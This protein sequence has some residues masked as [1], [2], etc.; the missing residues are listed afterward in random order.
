[1]PIS[2]YRDISGK[3]ERKRRSE[4]ARVAAIVAAIQAHLEREAEAAGRSIPGFRVTGLRSLTPGDPMTAP[5]YP[6][7]WAHAGRMQLMQSRLDIALRKGR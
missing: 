1:M 7:P 3:G 4:A 6:S 5:A 2:L